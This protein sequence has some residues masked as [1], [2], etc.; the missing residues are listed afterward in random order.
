MSYRKK[1]LTTLVL[2]L[3]CCG[4]ISS[5]I[6]QKDA[7]LDVKKPE[8]YEKRILGSDKT[9][10]TKYNI[11]RR[12]MQGM[13]THYNFFFNG[14]IKLNDIITGAKQAFR[15]DY[16]EL[17]PF[18]NYTLEAT[19]AQKTELDSVLQ[20]CNAA[21]LLHDLRNEWIDDMYFLMG[22]AYFFKDQ[23]DSAGITFQYLNYYFQPKK[24]EEL[25]F[26]KFVGSNLNDEG[27]VYNISTKERKGVVQKVFSE[28]PRRNDALV[29]LVRTFIEDSAFG[30]ASGLIQTL[31][32]D[33][34]FPERLKPS[35]EEMQAYFFYKQGMWDSA[36]HHLIPALS[37]AENMAEK[38]RW[39]YLIGQLFAL[40]KN[41]TEANKYFDL[42]IKHAID[43]VMMV[44]ARLNQI[45]LAHGDDDKKVIEDNIQELLKM[46]RRDRYYNYRNIIYYMAAQMEMERDN[47]DGAKTW[48]L[49][50]V[51]YNQEDLTQ[52][53]RS[54]L[55]LG[56][57]A[58]DHKQYELAA[59]A[60][61]SL[62]A[63]S[64][65][66]KNPEEIGQRKAALAEVISRLKTISMQDS[67]QKIAAMP[68]AER[69]KFLKAAAKR[70][71]KE[72]GLKETDSSSS[73]SSNN[74]YANKGGGDMFAANG[75]GDWYFYNNS[76]KSK[77]FSTFRSTWGTRPNV[78]N[79]RRITDVSA[80]SKSP[81]I[82]PGASPVPL[83]QKEEQL[84]DISYEGLLKTVPLTPE[85][86]T[87]SNDSVESAL[88]FLGNT[89]KDKFEDYGEAVKKYEELL[90]RFPNTPNLEE[91]LFNLNYCYTK[92]NLP[93]KAKQYR[94]LLTQHNKQSK[95]LRFIDD[96]KA[97]LESIN[98]LQTD[99]T[100]NY[101]RI[102]NMFLE[103]N[104]EQAVIEKIKADSLFGNVY[105]TQQLL[106]IES[107]YYIKQRDDSSAISA[108]RNLIKINTESGMAKKAENIIDVLK[109]RASIEKYLTDLNIERAE[110]DAVTL[111]EEK[112]PE[113]QIV[114]KQPEPQLK[115]PG[116]EQVAQRKPEP[117]TTDITAPKATAARPAIDSSMLK[118]PVVKQS[119]F[120]YNP[121]EPHFVAIVLNK[122]DVVYVNEVRN[123]FNRYNRESYRAQ[124][125]EISIE[126]LDDNNKLILMS[127]FSDAAAAL[128][129]VERTK[130][131]AGAQIVPWLAADK[132]Y[133]TIISPANL[134]V[135]RTN[136]N[137]DIYKNFVQSN[138]PG[139]Q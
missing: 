74:P 14:E 82:N 34:I 66:I 33:E 100:K 45:K 95:Y 10:T 118:K 49:K 23:M 22:K 12:L 130:K 84:T 139:Q 115:A 132:Y 38:A 78:D 30:H 2:F 51:T 76:L 44:Y 64:P 77:G 127:D 31:K 128:E 98:K 72:R 59:K 96:P 87:A 70:L 94:E 116:K 71:R 15:D 81:N 11:P 93:V 121:A 9:F 18:Y 79:W 20:K 106:Y 120:T 83:D 69:E 56:N 7:T 111:P 17:L 104:F 134:D 117:K 32:R 88:F 65:L 119:G 46:A 3:F 4:F 16:T 131:V 60:Y 68:E 48:L 40:S 19:A 28:P 62:D 114:E 124:P 26:K 113:Q 54:Y 108:L 110:E 135:L 50:S 103:G 126:A 57:L 99:A 85:A 122:V 37:N 136:K 21:I 107:I 97:A 25:G 133:L 80:R 92:L 13:S 55:Y 112:K 8:K 109:R 89:F 39:E 101:E 137:L 123:A 1:A 52:K 75:K 41:K 35:F 67:L 105:W 43:P 61:D 29:W 36:A 63:G 125:I 73:F 102:Y 91:A 5:A 90:N 86:L 53:N 27:N 24:P 42:S 47:F 58:F 138:Y 129:Y 6:A